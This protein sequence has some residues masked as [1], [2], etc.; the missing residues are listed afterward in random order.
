MTA[1]GNKD[2]QYHHQLWLMMVSAVIHCPVD[3]LSMPSICFTYIVLYTFCQ[4]M[5][6]CRQMAK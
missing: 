6:G 5:E 4:G 1:D 2:G 3:V